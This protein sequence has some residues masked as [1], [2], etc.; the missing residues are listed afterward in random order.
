[1]K[2]LRPEDK[3]FLKYVKG[4]QYKQCPSCKFWVSKNQ[5]CDH[6]TCRC[7]YEFCYQCGAKYGT[8]ECQSNY[9][10][11]DDDDFLDDIEEE[12]REHYGI[13]HPREQE[14]EY[15]SD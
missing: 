10:D 12:S 3:Q 13:R 6:M 9:D 5:G 8:C 7:G 15:N 1:M 11:D 14:E 4:A 2:N